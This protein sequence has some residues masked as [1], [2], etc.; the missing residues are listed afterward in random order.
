MKT[1]AKKSRSISIRLSM[2]TFNEL[3]KLLIAQ[4][5]G[6][7]NKRARAQAALLRRRLDRAPRLQ[8]A[9]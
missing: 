8:R 6:A 7:G 2:R 4:E 1:K 5:E 9:A 3:S